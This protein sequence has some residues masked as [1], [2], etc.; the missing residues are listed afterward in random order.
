MAGK[1]LIVKYVSHLNPGQHYLLVLKLCMFPNSLCDSG[2]PGPNLGSGRPFGLSFIARP[3]K[4]YP[5][6]RWMSAQVVKKQ[7][8]QDAGCHPS[9]SIGTI[10]RLVGRCEAKNEEQPWHVH[11]MEHGQLAIYSDRHQARVSLFDSILIVTVN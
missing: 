5:L 11:K 4:E 10:S 8:S 2:L 1:I 7:F 6:L 3:R 9:C